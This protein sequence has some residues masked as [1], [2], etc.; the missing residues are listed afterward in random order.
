MELPPGISPGAV[1]GRA[2]RS[3]GQSFSALP[4]LTHWP[5]TIWKFSALP[6]HL[7][8]GAALAIPADDPARDRATRTVAVMR[9]ALLMMLSAEVVDGSRPPGRPARGTDVR[10]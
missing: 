8:L 10:S 4:S 1:V 5:L 6:A 3:S 2:L 9:L 7:S